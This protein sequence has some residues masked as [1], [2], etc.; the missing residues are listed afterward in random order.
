[1]DRASTSTALDRNE[2]P[3]GRSARAGDRLPFD[4]L[5][6]LFAPERHQLYLDVLERV[7]DHADTRSVAVTGP[8]G[9]GKSSVLR[10]LTR[11]RWSSRWPWLRRRV[12]TTLSLS[13]LAPPP[14]QAAEESNPAEKDAS[15]PIQKELVKQLLYRLPTTR[16]PRSRFPR[17]SSPSWGGA[18]MVGVLASLTLTGVA[19]LAA[20]LTGWRETLDQRLDLLGWEPGWTW[21]AAG[22][23]V[24]VLAAAIWRLASGR[25]ELK[26]DLKASALTV[27]LG[28]TS[29]SYFDQYLDEIVYFFQVSRTNIL[30]IEDID[31]FSDA[32]VFDTLRALNTLVNGSKQVG[33]RVVFVYAM[34]DSVLSEIGTRPL[35][36][37]STDPD[38]AT[39]ALDR[40]NRA[41]YFDAIIPLVPFVTTNNARDLLMEVMNPAE[42]KVSPALLRL[43]ARHVADM[44]TLRSLRNEFE[45]HVDRLMRTG[46][47]RP[48][49]SERPRRRR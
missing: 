37:G 32:V 26:G 36:D 28:L 4:S 34:R 12:V 9:S 17:A 23:G 49:A 18:L 40:S 24:L 21:T 33:R 15:N 25:I 16:T 42:T 11:W 19:Y 35:P 2:I 13:T 22:I 47:P 5:A 48:T 14:A 39:L 46:Q 10:G 20:A 27:S 41:K 30:V 1:M 31:R 8:Y 38:E 29:S 45:V 6:P 44:R 7:L 3:V 43:A